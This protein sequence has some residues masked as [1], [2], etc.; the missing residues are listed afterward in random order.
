VEEPFADGGVDG[1]RV[2]VSILVA[3]KSSR[4][5][6]SYGVEE[7]VEDGEAPEETA[8]EALVGVDGGVGPFCRLSSVPFFFE[9]GTAF[10]V[11]L[12]WG[13]PGRVSPPPRRHRRRRS[14]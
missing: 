9:S 1:E 4:T 8:I 2:G 11:A 12:G 7:M 6:V 14:R 13:E 3:R 5:P 10:R